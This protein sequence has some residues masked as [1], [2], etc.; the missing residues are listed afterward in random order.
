MTTKIATNSN[1]KRGRPKGRVE[2]RVS[3]GF[4]LRESLNARLIENSVR[5]KRSANSIV[6]TALEREFEEKEASATP[7]MLLGQIVGAVETS[8]E[9]VISRLLDT[10]LSQAIRDGVIVDVGQT[11]KD[12]L[13]ELAREMKVSGA[14]HL[15]KTLLLSALNNPDLARQLIA[16]QT[17]QI[18][19]R[20]HSQTHS[21]TEV[22]GE[23]HLKAA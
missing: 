12:Q 13:E 21:Q 11:H 14:N 16:S 15:M 18:K 2:P 4:H 22:E 20:A 7:E 17:R 23:S 1:K 10:Y 5:T 8:V 19:G 9:G 3:R 6:E